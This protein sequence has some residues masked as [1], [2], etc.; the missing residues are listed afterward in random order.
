MKLSN[1]IQD[2]EVIRVVGDTER[3]IA[4][5]VF[6]SRTVTAGSLFVAIPGTVV[7]GHQYIPQAVKA[8]T[9]A[10]VCEEPP[11]EKDE[12]VTYIITKNSRRAVALIASAWYGHPSREINLVGI[13]GTNGKTTIATLLY[14]V[15]TGLG[16]KAG[17]LTTIEI[18][19]HDRSYPAT[20][21]TPDPLQ[22]NRWL[23]E[24]VDRG[25]EYCFMEVSSHA[26]SQHRIDGLH[27]KGGV[28]TNLTHD[29]LDYHKD[30]REYL[31]AKQS[32][33]NQ[34]GEEAFALT[35]VDDKNGEVM[36]QGCRAKKYRYGMKRIADYHGRVLESHFEGMRLKINEKE[37][38]VRLTGRFNASNI[39]AVFGTSLLLGHNEL[40]VLEAIS[41]TAAAEGRFEVLRGPGGQVAVIDYAHTDDALRNVLETIREVNSE[42]RQIITV[43]GAG[44]DRDRTKRAKMGNVA[45]KLS[46]KV[47]FTSDN[48]RSEDPAAIMRE[49]EQGVPAEKAGDVLKIA[50][51]EEAI[52]TACMLGGVDPVILVAGKGHEKYQEI[53]GERRHFDDKEIV[54]RYLK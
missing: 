47:I 54:K 37:V 8:G 46:D 42:E 20:H 5:V 23:R 50:D 30:F 15:N 10:V 14:K 49:M 40:Q 35:N 45:A 27:F 34:L 24:M 17:I 29:H 52:R 32:F 21:T 43:V 31:V 7:D 12:G 19:I 13:T 4:A 22:I 38:W 51:R 26:A 44:G 25:C 18:I 16:Y 2:L 9:A 41:S 1:L 11:E 36:L 53:A 3:E 39:L 6:D 33:F 48:P 28:F